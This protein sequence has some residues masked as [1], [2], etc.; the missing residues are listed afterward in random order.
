MTM[1]VHHI[2]GQNL[3][4]HEIDDLR[5]ISR[6]GKQVIAERTRMRRSSAS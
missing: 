5:R 6:S 4:T 2:E 3:L 1:N